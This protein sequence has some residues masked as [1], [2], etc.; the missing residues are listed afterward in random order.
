MG[1]VWGV[2]S[3]IKKGFARIVA[4]CIGMRLVEP[5]F[6]P[7]DVGTLGS[8]HVSLGASGLVRGDG[9]FPFKADVQGYLAF[10]V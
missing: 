8:Q 7:K 9:G 3:K 1:F 4:D 10:R 5:D 2:R 6:G